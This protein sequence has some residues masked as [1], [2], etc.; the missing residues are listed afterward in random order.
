MATDARRTPCT[1]PIRADGILGKRTVR[2]AGWGERRR[3]RDRLDELGNFTGFLPAIS[4][5]AQKKINTEIRSWWL[6]RQIHLTFFDLARRI[7]PIVRG[8]MNYYGAFYRS[9]LHPLLHRINTYLMRWVRK[10]YRRLRS[11]KKAHAC[12]NR[13]TRQYPRLFAQWAWAPEFR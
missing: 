7:N 1:G 9:E 3:S 12:W 10:K 8:W 4:K 5:D 6:H 13:V 2:A 11:F